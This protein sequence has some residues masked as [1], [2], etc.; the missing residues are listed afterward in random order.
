MGRGFSYENY[1]YVQVSGMF[2][3]HVIVMFVRN[4]PVG[5]SKVRRWIYPGLRRLRTVDRLF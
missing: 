5:D 4:F 1:G 2:R 3:N